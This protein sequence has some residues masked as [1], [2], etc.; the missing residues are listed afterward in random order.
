MFE[1][2]LFQ[3]ACCCEEI[4]LIASSY[5]K[6]IDDIDS[7]ISELGSLTG[8][9]QSISNLKQKKETL[10]TQYQMLLSMAQG[11]GKIRINYIKT[12]QQIFDNVDGIVICR[13]LDVIEEPGYFTLNSITPIE[14]IT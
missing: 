9:D 5:K 10:K 12:E 7:I 1:V 2:F 8:L 4:E 14:F 13:R 11:L 6:E 3:L